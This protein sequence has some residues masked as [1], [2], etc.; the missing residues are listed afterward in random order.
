MKR[1]SKKKTVTSE[2]APEKKKVSR[3]KA[4]AKKK[5]TPVKK[6]ATKKAVK[7]TTGTRTRK[8]TVL[9]APP[10]TRSTPGSK[11]ETIQMDTRRD[12][13]PST[14]PVLPTEPEPGLELE[15]IVSPPAKQELPMEPEPPHSPEIPEASKKSED[16]IPAPDGEPETSSE[17]TTKKDRF[18]GFHFR[19][20]EWMKGRENPEETSTLFFR[21]NQGGIGQLKI[22]CNRKQLELEPG[23]LSARHLRVLRALL[24]KARI[25]GIETILEL[26]SIEEEREKG[27]AELPPSPDPEGFQTYA[28]TVVREL[29]DLVNRFITFHSP[30][31]AILY[32]F[33]NPT[34]IPGG[35]EGYGQILSYTR[36]VLLSHFKAREGI[37]EIQARLG[38]PEPEIGFTLAAYLFVPARSGSRGD[39]DRARFLEKRTTELWKQC[40]LEGIFSP[41]EGHSE[42]FS[43]S[44]GI[45]FLSIDY[46]GMV[47][48]GFHL[49]RRNRFFIRIQPLDRSIQGLTHSLSKVAG[50]SGK[51]VLIAHFP[52]GATDPAEMEAGLLGELSGQEPDDFS[53]DGYLHSG[54]LTL[55]QEPSKQSSLS[56]DN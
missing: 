17:E 12:E 8:K 55:N 3:K 56:G 2:V 30:N 14:S 43:P 38:R 40:L 44:G 33:E 4:T 39:M 23:K 49:F 32:F 34:G 47:N 36:N 10:S 7:K 27:K 11:R 16:R 9:P 45:D 46:R 28:E 54:F 15:T 41:L 35:P 20:Q 18:R 22:G 1:S 52:S 37:R 50:G 5:S 6:K 19:L 42:S 51:P 29:G 13:L 21:L 26:D 31:Q 25:F 48:V 53:I 24:G